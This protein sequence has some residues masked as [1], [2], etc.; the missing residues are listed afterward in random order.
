MGLCEIDVSSCEIDSFESRPMPLLPLTPHHHATV[1]FPTPCVHTP[2][3]SHHHA[4]VYFPTPCVHTP[5]P[6]ADVASA[7]QD[8]PQ[9]LIGSPVGTGLP[10]I[11]P[12]GSW[13]HSA[14]EQ[15]GQFSREACLH[16]VKK[17][18]GSCTPSLGCNNPLTSYPG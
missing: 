15:L 3:V 13:L 10:T 5:S 11:E 17:N 1:Y 6:D 12:G 14:R 9:T 4:T 16:R 2:S 8:F 18:E 7:W